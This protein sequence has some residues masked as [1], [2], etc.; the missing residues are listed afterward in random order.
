MEGRS[1]AGPQSDEAFDGARAQASSAFV[2]PEVRQ[3][4]VKQQEG[5]VERDVALPDWR[6]NKYWN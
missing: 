2:L 5:W 3:Q 1:A 4:A 6:S